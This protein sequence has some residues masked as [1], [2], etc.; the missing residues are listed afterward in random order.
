MNNKILKPKTKVLILKKMGLI[1]K[2]GE[3]SA[4]NIVRNLIENIIPKCDEIFI[5]VGYIL[6]LV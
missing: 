4:T 6:S 3:N 5:E 2:E 1:K